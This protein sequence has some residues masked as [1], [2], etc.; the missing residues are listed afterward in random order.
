MYEK[1]L[2]FI[3]IYEKIMFLDL[4]RYSI[5]LIKYI[6]IAMQKL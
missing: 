5:K 2:K 6:K 1:L 3:K 4:N